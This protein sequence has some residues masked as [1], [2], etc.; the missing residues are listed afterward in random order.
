MTTVPSAPWGRFAAQARAV[1]KISG[2]CRLRALQGDSDAR[3][4]VADFGIAQTV[5]RQEQ[6]L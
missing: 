2:T 5:E 1:I 6:R 3:V 4:L